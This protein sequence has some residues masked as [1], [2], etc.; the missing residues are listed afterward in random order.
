MVLMKK[1]QYHI[2]KQITMF[3]F[4]KMPFNQVRDPSL[5]EIQGILSNLDGI[6]DIDGIL[7]YQLILQ[8]FQSG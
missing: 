2:C 6:Q 5:Q 1:A 4:Q 3:I 7:T 8:I